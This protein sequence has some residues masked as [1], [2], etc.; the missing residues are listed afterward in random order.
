MEKVNRVFLSLGSNIE[1]RLDHLRKAIQQIETNI[2]RIISLSSI[3]E[4]EAVG[5]SSEVT[6][7][8]MCLELE[9]KLTPGHLLQKT[10]EIELAIGRK[11]KTIDTYESRKI[12]IDIIFYS[13]ERIETE[14]LSVPHMQYMNRKFVLMPLCEIDETIIDPNKG[15]SIR[16]ILLKCP[17][18][19]IV[20]RTSLA[21]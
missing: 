2:G 7:Y 8:N 10:Q 12:D 14:S 16:E 6:F 15:I 17:D 11:N 20:K 18:N 1:S 13:N 21:I 9:T 4:S 3:Y 5:F 19:S